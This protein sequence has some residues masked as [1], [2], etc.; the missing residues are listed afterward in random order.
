MFQK[1]GKNYAIL[2]TC[3]MFR[4][5]ADSGNVCTMTQFD[6]LLNDLQSIVG[7]SVAVACINNS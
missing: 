2:N 6:F 5:S 3:F 1:P 4:Q 7:Q